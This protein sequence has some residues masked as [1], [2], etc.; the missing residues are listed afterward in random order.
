MS[1]EKQ[2][3]IRRKHGKLSA[4]GASLVDEYKK[5]IKYNP[6][7][8]FIILDMS[9]EY[10]FPPT[11]LCRILLNTI[12]EGRPKPEITKMLR[13]Y[14]LI[15]DPYL[16]LNVSHCIFNDDQ[17]GALTDATRRCIGEEYELRLKQLARD[18]G[19]IFYD[20]GDLRR[21]GYDKTPDLKLAIPVLY[22]P[23]DQVIYWIESKALFGDPD[24]HR[25]YLQ[26]QL[27]SYGNR[28]GHGI[29]IYWLGYLDEIVYNEDNCDYLTILD[30]FPEL[31]E[32]ETINL[33]LTLEN[34]E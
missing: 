27:M 10:E 12:Y 18:A 31:N 14:N 6:K 28:F 15:P 30:K 29:V 1:K 3:Q 22:K 8:N 25:K 32:L 26:D 11:A 34:I 2:N 21:E 20:E 17:E 19:L 33:S 16:S 9:M 5:R 7:N 4:K 24:S 23:T 13:N